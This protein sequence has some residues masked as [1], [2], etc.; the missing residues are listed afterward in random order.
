MSEQ[1]GSQQVWAPLCHAWPNLEGLLFG[2]TSVTGLSRR[3]RGRCAEHGR[4]GGGLEEPEGGEGRGLYSIED[5]KDKG[6]WW[7]WGLF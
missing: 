4:E 5:K 7:R 6:G 3:G 2:R 1:P